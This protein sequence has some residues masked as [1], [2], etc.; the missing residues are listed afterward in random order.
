MKLEFIKFM[1]ITKPYYDI[2]VQ[3]DQLYYSDKLKMQL[4][5]E[6][7]G[8]RYCLAV[9]ANTKPIINYGK[10]RLSNNR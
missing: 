8:K 1:D 3:L 7:D 5:P 4:V 10:S 2:N 6:I 9:T